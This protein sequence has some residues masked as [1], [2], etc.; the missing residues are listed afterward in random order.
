MPDINCPRCAGNGKIKLSD[1]YQ[2]TL[3]ALRMLGGRATVT[4]LDRLCGS[5]NECGS[6]TSKRIQRLAQM[7]LVTLNRKTRPMVVSLVKKG[8][9]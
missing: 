3:E 7:G 9:G 5:R 6:T 1:A 8:R 2:P 4:E